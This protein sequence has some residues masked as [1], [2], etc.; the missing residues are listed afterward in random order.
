MKRGKIAGYFYETQAKPDFYEQLG[1]VLG[2]DIGK[3]LTV[4]MNDDNYS[5]FFTHAEG[6]HQQVPAVA[7]SAADYSKKSAVLDLL[8]KVKQASDA[9]N[10]GQLIDTIIRL[11]GKV[12]DENSELKDENGKLKDQ[13]L[14]LSR[15][16]LN[17][18]K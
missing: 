11:Y 5:S 8:L 1:E 6:D 17:E 16:L 3:F 10:R 7:E 18:G 9:T 12:L 2:V 14:E 15:R 13:L 4:S